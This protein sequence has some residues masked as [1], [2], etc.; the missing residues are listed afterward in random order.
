MNE[1]LDSNN[2]DND[3]KNNF[4]NYNQQVLIN[5]DIE[6]KY[7]FSI[8]SNPPPECSFNPPVYVE[9]RFWLVTV[10]GT[11]IAII[12]IIENAFLFS[13]LA[14]KRKYRNSYVLYLL[15]LAL[16]DILIGIAYIPLMSLSLYLDYIQSVILLRAWYAYMIPMITVSHI[17]MTSTTFLIV[18]ASWERY[19]ITASNTKM[20][21]FL[22][23]YRKNI[24]GGAVILGMLTKISLAFEFDIKFIPRCVNTMAEYE[25]NSS[26]LAL[27]YYY[28]L[29]WRLIF[30]NI[31]TILAPFFFLLII[32][33]RVVYILHQYPTTI[34]NQFSTDKSLII[35]DIEK[36]SNNPKL[37]YEYQ[38][39]VKVR[40]ATKTL[41][42]VALSYILS[43]FLNVILTLWEYIDIE[44]LQFEYLSFYTITVDLVSIFTVLVGVLRLPIYV[45]CMPE[46]R[47]EF[48]NYFHQMFNPKEYD[49]MLMVKK[50]PGFLRKFIHNQYKGPN[51]F[52]GMGEMWLLRPMQ[53][54]NHED[55]MLDDDSL[56]SSPDF[57][58]GNEYIED[59]FFELSKDGTPVSIK[60]SSS[61]LFDNKSIMDNLKDESYH[62]ISSNNKDSLNFNEVFL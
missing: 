39:K 14:R 42:F 24:A 23:K 45:A 53:K 26:S 25:L 55:V 36:K 35:N 37:S 27:S 41:L 58:D 20:V 13:M 54:G 61:N 3:V 1:L 38:R 28:A 8:N 51:I 7:N 2:K 44:L 5:N 56:S 33:A 4:H 12:C 9:E 17:A 15:L 32:N 50:K 43:N 21:R 59:G 11:I 6:Y 22:N 48:T 40:A 30:R 19:C 60:I 49:E 52:I 34:I 16:F 47:I 46:M 18:A 10:A 57:I 29:F 62:S 31:F